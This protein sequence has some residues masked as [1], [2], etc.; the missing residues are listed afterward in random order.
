MNATEQIETQ[1]ITGKRESSLED[2]GTEETLQH[3]EFKV[4]VRPEH[5]MRRSDAYVRPGR[6]ALSL[7]LEAMK[8]IRLSRPLTAHWELFTNTYKVVPDSNNFHA[9]LQNL[10]LR[11][12]SAEA[13][14]FIQQIPKEWL[15]MKTFRIAMSTCARDKNNPSSFA[16]AGKVL[17]LMQQNMSEMDI[18]TL[19]KYLEV[20]LYGADD[21]VRVP[22]GRSSIEADYARGRRILRALERLAPCIIN[23]RSALAY[24]ER[25][26]SRFVSKSDPVTDLAS[27]LALIR[28]VISAYDKL[29][30]HGMVPVEM[31]K[32]I[33][34]E[35]SK[36]AAFVTRYNAQPKKMLAVGNE[37][38]GQKPNPQPEVVAPRET[39]DFGVQ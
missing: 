19:G 6:N 17:D 11:R 33:K 15:E 36:L 32:R 9:Y 27:A 29:M 16:H 22:T 26:D 8:R 3:D 37:A 34:L 12:A 28:E 1:Q 25:P 23:V 20:A 7:V 10:R 2:D 35:R 14:N 18:L 5:I 30:S 39:V 31:N 4:V 13:V 21:R 38:G 24:S